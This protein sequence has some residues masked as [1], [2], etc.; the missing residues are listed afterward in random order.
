MTA[1]RKP[2]A[3]VVGLDCITG[4]QTARIL[5]GHGISVIAVAKDSDHYCCRTNVCERILFADTASEEFV[6]VLLGLDLAATAVLYPCTDMAVLTISRNRARLA[7]RFHFALPP[8]EVV[9]TLMDK[10]AFVGLAK[11]KNLP[12]PLTF[13]LRCRED[14]ERAASEL[15][16]P[17]ILKPPL[18][19]PT[20]EANTSLKVFRI[21]SSSELLE[22][23]DRCAAWADVLMVQEWVE[24]TD[25]DLY[26]CNCY[27]DRSS[28]PL[29]TFI[30]R[31]LRQWPPRTGTSC[32]GEECRNDVVLQES[33]RLFE[34]VGYHGLGYVEM[35]RDSRTGK[36]SII[37]PNIG[38][39]TGRSAISEAGGVPL[40]Y[41]MYCDLTGQPLPA[42][43]EQTYRGAKW[44]SFRRDAQ[45]AFYYWRRGELSLLE[46]W[47]SWQGKKF[48]AV[49]SWTD[50]A[51]F[52]ADLTRSIGL[53][54]Q[55]AF[56]RKTREDAPVPAR[57][58]ATAARGQA[59]VSPGAPA[60]ARPEASVGS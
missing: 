40:L 19:T 50:P 11:E 23:Y 21:E 31:K 58:E 16:Y 27:F 41:T 7:K 17:C 35:K 56:A 45:S 5:S 1:V 57:S 26:S 55:Q 54:V 30:A 2:P 18:K 14:A 52:F 43:R 39:P 20:W 15:S 36:H 51:P 42:G 37:E 29:V 32:L 49:W 13:L 33:V 60:P 38:R 25:S 44:I 48:D 46:W 34:S 3:I 59:A 22:T 10:I 9:E 8:E 4:L 12:I 53:L 28:K 6:E 47:R 24:G